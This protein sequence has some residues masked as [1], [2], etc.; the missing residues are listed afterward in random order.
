MALCRHSSDNRPMAKP[1]PRLSPD[2]IKRV[3]AT[4]FD[5]LPPYNKVLQEFAITQGELVQLMKRELTSPAY[6]LWVAQGK[7]FKK[8]TAKSTFPHGR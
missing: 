7:G 4:A 6:K 1:I 3:I 5:D 8:P 2:Q